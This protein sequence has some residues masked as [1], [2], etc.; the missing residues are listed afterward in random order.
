MIRHSTTILLISCFFLFS[1]FIDGGT[2]KIGLLKYN[3]GGDWYS[4]PTSLPNLI[5][6]C[7]TNLNTNIHADYG[8]VEVGSSE[9]FN[10]PMLHMTGH[11]NVVFSNQDVIN[12]KSYLE[13]G[14]FL[15]I[16]DNYGMDKFVRRE[17]KK[18]FPDQDFVELPFNHPIY[19]QQY[20]FT[21]G[22]PKVHEHDKLPPQG[23][24]LFFEGKLVCFYTYESDLGDGWE[25]P[26]VHG[27]SEVVRQKAL[28]MGANIV[29]YAFKQ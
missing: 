21:K 22:L 15:H 4:N 9:V 23:F 28:E 17:M 5:K 12:L 24:G 1:S 11:G 8:T 26:A 3:G 14:G 13:A 20:S 25:D 18:V 7:N 10:Y 29:S 6:F 16:D 2:V 27:D 19:N